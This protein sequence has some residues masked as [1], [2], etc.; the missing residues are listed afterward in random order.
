MCKSAINTTSPAREGLQNSASS[1][2]QSGNEL[3]ENIEKGGWM[4][5]AM[6][7]T[8]CKEICLKPHR[9]WLEVAPSELEYARWTHKLHIFARRSIGFHER[10]RALL[11]EPIPL[12]ISHLHPGRSTSRE[13]LIHCGLGIITVHT[14][15]QRLPQQWIDTELAQYKCPIYII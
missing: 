1:L 6:P 11:A 2:P 5:W 10:S 9:Y 12:A 14:Q 15:G 4:L 3:S 8:R 7:A 13:G